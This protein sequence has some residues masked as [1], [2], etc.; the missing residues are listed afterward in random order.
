MIRYLIRIQN[1]KSGGSCFK[2]NKL[3]SSTSN[4]PQAG[5]ALTFFYSQKK[6]QKVRPLCSLSL[7]MRF[8][9][10]KSD[11]LAMAFA[12]SAIAHRPSLY[13]LGLSDCSHSASLG[14]FTQNHFLRLILQGG[15]LLLIK[16]IFNLISNKK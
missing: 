11:K 8:R 6:K 12:V 9:C 2:L 15:N 16:K 13:L 14:R 4:S 10:A 7:K 1:Q 5:W 3:G